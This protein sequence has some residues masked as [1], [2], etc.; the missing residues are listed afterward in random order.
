MAAAV[1]AAAE[2]GIK[3]PPE[4]EP[5]WQ[6]SVKPPVKDTITTF[7]ADF[8]FRPDL[9]TKQIEISPWA[10][11]LDSRFVARADS[12]DLETYRSFRDLDRVKSGWNSS[13]NALLGKTELQRRGELRI[14]LA[15]PSAV[16]SIVGEGGAGL[17]VSGYRKILF[18]G[19]SQW[20]DKASTATVRQSKFPS[21]SMEQISKFTVEGTIGSK[22]SVKVDQDSKRTSDLE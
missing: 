11:D 9:R 22:I 5:R 12:L 2:P 19:R 10:L 7:K 18:S 6:F 15:L 4:G 14:G 21:L 16:E 13:I 17:K 1:P 20:T 8:G 3:I